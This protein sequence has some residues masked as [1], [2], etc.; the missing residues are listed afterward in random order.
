M[1]TT[2]TTD[3][4]STTSTV[5]PE[6]AFLEEEAK[7]Y[8]R[9]MCCTPQKIEGRTRLGCLFGGLCCC[10]CFL[11]VTSPIWAA[12][13]LVLVLLLILV[14]LASCCLCCFGCGR[15]L[16]MKFVNKVTACWTSSFPCCFCCCLTGRDIA[17]MKLDANMV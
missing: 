3:T 10:Y 6:E 5:D 2:S 17:E 15:L 16:D 1:S 9:C 7:K 14:F 12:L 4:A 8:E 13:L 11:I